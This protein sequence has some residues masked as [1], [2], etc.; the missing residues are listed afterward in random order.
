MKKICSVFLSQLC[1][2]NDSVFIRQTGF[3]ENQKNQTVER[4]E[5]RFLKKLQIFSRCL[6]QKIQIV[7][8]TPEF[9]GEISLFSEQLC[10]R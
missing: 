7:F 10:F 4:R 1:L 2:A 3:W 9:N 8:L 6:Q 5:M